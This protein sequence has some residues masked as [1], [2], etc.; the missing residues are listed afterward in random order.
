MK[1]K[2]QEINGGIKQKMMKGIMTPLVA[3]F[4]L[5]GIV[6]IL[7]TRAAV[8][9]IRSS[10][11]TAESKQ[12]S[13]LVS[14]YFTRYMWLTTELAANNELRV[15]MEETKAGD[16]LTT[17]EQYASVL[18]TMTNT[19]NCDEENI[20]VC[21]I[22]D[23][24]SSRCV[25]DENSGY[26]SPMGEWDITSRPWYTEVMETKTTIIT[27]PYENASLGLM[28]SS[29]I[30]PV[31]GNNGEITG[32]A[33]VDVSVDTLVKMMSQHSL[34]KKGFF[35]LFSPEG[36]IMYAPQEE[37]LGTAV[38]DAGMDDKVLRA[39]EEKT[40][41]NLVYRWNGKK[42]GSY[43]II[44][45]TGWSV[46]S[47]MPSSEYNQ[48]ITGLVVVIALFFAVAI[49][50][51]TIIIERIARGIVDPLK[52]LEVAAEEIAEGDLDI[53]IDVN[54]EDEVGKVASALSK[55]VDRLKEYIKYIDEVTE[56]LNEIAGGNLKFELKQAYMGEFQKVK[57]GLEDLSK[58]LTDTLQNI[59]EASV[60]VSGGAEQISTGAMS[61]ADGATSQAAGIQQL[62][63]SVTEISTQVSSTAK[64]ADD[65]KKSVIDMNREIEFSNEQMKNAVQAMDEISRCSSQIENII[66]TIEEIADQTNLLSLNASIEAARAGEL[67][68]GF[69][70]VAGEVGS[71]AGESMN[72]VQTST[73]L[74][75]DSLDA[76][77]NGMDIVN[78]AAVQMQ[79]AMEHIKLLQNLIE[80][81]DEACNKQDDGIEQVRRALGQVSEVI[82]DNSAMAEESAAASQELSAQ[83]QSLTNMIKEFKM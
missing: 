77:K 75:K 35:M 22:A 60:Q 64:F 40:E 76:V 82:S 39:M 65:A 68:R 57:L 49:V 36:N 24:D 41:K 47:G 11:I 67:G 15:L 23:V 9:D 12:V 48:A 38:A 31:F 63:A 72:A 8:S 16:D 29:V 37:L 80:N 78:G 52:N 10:E 44:G 43:M 50:L 34:G 54:S 58:R 69:A 30:S 17:S 62:Q 53:N 13:N 6:S 71:L 27:E 26:V 5:V 3:V 73:S 14:E 59:D 1:G 56:V 79:Q 46:L 81:I 25:E 42:Y 19:Y 61:L 74:I 70:V 18:K 66:T 55:T 20:L 28:V 7:I 21:W 83:S 45:D 51:L 32:V 33:A 4:F 2:K